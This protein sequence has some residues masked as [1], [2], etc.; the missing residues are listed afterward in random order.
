MNGECSGFRVATI[1]ERSIHP[2]V[3][4]RRATMSQDTK[5]QDTKSQDTKSQDTK[6][7]DTKPQETTILRQIYDFAN[8]ATPYPLWAKLRQTPVSWQ[9]DGPQEAGTYVVSTYREIEAL[10]HDSRVSSDLRNSLQ[11]GGRTRTTTDRKSVV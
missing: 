7:Q 5:S 1:H 4:I 2:S 11:T 9:A 6:S 10:L 8:R 3:R